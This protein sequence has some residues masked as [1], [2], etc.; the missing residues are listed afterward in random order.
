MCCRYLI[1]ITDVLNCLVFLL[2]VMAFKFRL[3]SIV[4]VIKKKQVTAADFSIFVKRL[5]KGVCVCDLVCASVC[6][7]FCGPTG[8]R[9]AGGVCN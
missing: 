3:N 8:P 1:T 5:P 9:H 4:K 6:V 7:C 2:A